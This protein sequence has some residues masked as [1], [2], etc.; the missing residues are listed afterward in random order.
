MKRN[1]FVLLI[2]IIILAGCNKEKVFLTDYFSKTEQC[3]LTEMTEYPVDSIGAPNYIFSVDDYIFLSEPKMEYLVS[4]YNISSG[5][6]KY[7][8]HKGNGPEELISINQIGQYNDSSIFMESTFSNVLFTYAN[9][10]GFGTVDRIIETPANVSSVFY[11]N[12]VRICTYSHNKEKRF[13]IEDVTKGTHAYFGAKISIPDCPED[14]IT[15]ALDGYTTGN[16]TSKKF[17]WAFLSGD[18]LEIYDYSD[19]SNVKLVKQFLGA[20]P[21][22]SMRSGMP[23]LKGDS[24]NKI[25]TVSITCDDKYI[26]ALY[27]E[28]LFKEFFTEFFTIKENALLC[29]KILIYDWNGKPVKIL[30]TDKWIRSIAYNKKYNRL[31]CVVYDFEDQNYRMFFIDNHQTK[32]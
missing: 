20:M 2:F 5:D 3:N 25:G 15:S 27:D 22:I 31:Y 1:V 24:N 26:Y 14:M 12:D 19:T 8:L 21:A 13:S 6:F 32:I 16:S 23:A 30:Q 29:N 9:S 17:A 18:A 28:H 10:G 7:F 11:D 4:A